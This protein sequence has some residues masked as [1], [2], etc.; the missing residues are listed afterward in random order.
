MYMYIYL[1]CTH[2]LPGPS[3]CRFMRKPDS[4]ICVNKGGEQVCD[5]RTA[6]QRLCFATLIVR[7]LYF[8][9]PKFQVSDH[10]L[11]L[12]S[13]VCVGPG[14]NPEDRFSYDAAHFCRGL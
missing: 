8:T 10:V 3:L 12:Y 11:L 14:R 4:C 9:Y 5:N 2:V 1:V 6:D 13:P 7:S